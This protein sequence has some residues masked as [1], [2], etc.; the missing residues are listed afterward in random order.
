MRKNSV[1]IDL[2]PISLYA[3]MLNATDLTT[4]GP[5]WFKSVQSGPIWS[6]VVQIGPEWSNLAQSGPIWS[7]VV[8]FGSMWSNLVHSGPNIYIEFQQ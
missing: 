2:G 7:K 6:K 8:Q 4:I 1:S 3:R 5:Y